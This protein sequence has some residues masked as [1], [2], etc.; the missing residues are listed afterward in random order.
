L[1][2]GRNFE[3]IG[4]DQLM[5]RTDF[6]GDLL[7]AFEFNCG[8]CGRDSGDGQRLFTELF[9]GDFQDDGAVDSAG[10]GDQYGLHVRDDLTEC[11]EF[12]IEGFGHHGFLPLTLRLTARGKT[13]L[14]R[15]YVTDLR[16]W[17]NKRIPRRMLKKPAQQG[18]SERRGEAYASVR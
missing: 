12:C 13:L 16:V 14:A 9:M 18:R 8:E 4:V 1:D 10:E 15:E 11:T 3:L 6:Q 17:N 7:G 2:E 5:P